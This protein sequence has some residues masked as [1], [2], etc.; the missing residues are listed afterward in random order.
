M[1]KK[2]KL[3]PQGQTVKGALTAYLTPK[4]AA[5]GKIKVGELNSIL[6]KITPGRYA[7]QVNGIVGTVNEQFGK[8]LVADANLEDLP[9]ILEALKA[10]EEGE[11]DPDEESEESE[12]EDTK[13][14]KDDDDD[15]DAYD[16]DEE[17]GVKLVKMLTSAKYGIPPEDL[18]IMNGLITAM[19]KPTADEDDDA[20]FPAK[21]PE[22]AM[23]KPELTPQ[24]LDAALVKSKKEVEASIGAKFSAAADVKPVVGE[25]DALAFDSAD[26]IY[27]LALDAKS[28]DISSAP[29]SAYKAMFKLCMTRSEVKP[30]VTVDATGVAALHVKYPNAPKVN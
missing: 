13:M 25:I 11:D 3:T 22:A 21:K 15:A 24:A 7:T 28:V 9:E 18:D 2:I 16:A 19:C 20:A 27:K 10:A 30:S 1:A 29:T 14:S 4:L 8:R 6:K 17:P 12:L 5:D 26:A 23:P